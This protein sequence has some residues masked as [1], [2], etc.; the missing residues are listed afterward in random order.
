MKHNKTLIL[1]LIK[2][3]LILTQF[4]TG[5][6]NLG[7]DAGKYYLHLSQTIFI[8]MGFGDFNKENELYEEYFDYVDKATTTNLLENPKQLNKIALELYNK[9]IAEKQKRRRTS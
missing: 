9:L 3:D 1:S 5:L 2:D 7:L 4:I 8:L 6:N